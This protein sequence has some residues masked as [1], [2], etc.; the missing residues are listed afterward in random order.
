MASPKSIE[1]SESSGRYRLALFVWAKCYQYKVWLPNHPF[2]LASTPLVL[3]LTTAAMSLC[4]NVWT[5]LAFVI[6]L[7][8]QAFVTYVNSAQTVAMAALRRDVWQEF[9]DLTDGAA[10]HLSQVLRH[11][12][13]RFLQDGVKTRP[14]AYKEKLLHLQQLLLDHIVRVLHR[15]LGDRVH[16]GTL[17][18][19]WAVRGS[20]EHSDRFRVVVYDRNMANRQPNN[21][22]KTIAD[23]L[24]GASVSFLA[25]EV[26]LVTDVKE[27]DN[28]KYFSPT[29]LYRS[30]L[31][32]PVMCSN[33]VV[34]V[35][36]VDSTE[37]GVLE[38]EQHLLIFDI[39]Y[40]V[41]LC[42]L[43]HEGA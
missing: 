13:G 17:S 35:V 39:V 11:Y 33:R 21:S 16:L 31:S 19:N 20:G 4:P 36:N 27:S 22:W 25:G 8:A 2:Y 24:P 6:G 26:S 23:D 18:A 30:I 9:A 12:D 32:I 3:G 5:I 15:H 42:Q 41:G 34:G 14:E 29:A 43:L 38:T 37:I 28:N 10:G 7:L 40:L 1:P